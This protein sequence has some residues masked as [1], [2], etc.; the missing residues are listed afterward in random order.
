MHGENSRARPSV[1]LSS[2]TLLVSISASSD[3]SRKLITFL[4]LIGVFFQAGGWTSVYADTE[5]SFVTPHTTQ[6]RTA[7]VVGNESASFFNWSRGIYF[8]PDVDYEDINTFSFMVTYISGATDGVILRIYETTDGTSRG[9]L[10]EESNE[11]PFT[12]FLEDT[13]NN[14]RADCPGLAQ[15][16]TFDLEESCFKANFITDD[17]TFE[18]GQK[19]LILVESIENET[20]PSPYRLSGRSTAAGAE[21]TGQNLT[22]GCKVANSCSV[23]TNSSVWTMWT[24]EGGVVD[25]TTRFDTFVPELGV[26]TPNATSTTF[27]LEVIGY[28]NEADYTTDETNIYMR[29][30]QATGM[31]LRGNSNIGSNG[32]FTW[33]PTTFGEFEATTTAEILNTGVYNIYWSIRKP[34]FSVFGFGFFNNTVLDVV[35]TFV[36]GDDVSETEI[37][38]NQLIIETTGGGIVDVTVPTSETATS[39]LESLPFS[40]GQ[41][42]GLREAI[43]SKFPFNWISGYV[44]VLN[45]LAESEATTTIPSV[46]INYGGLSLLQNVATSTAIDTEITFFSGATIDEVA[47]FTGIQSMRTFLGWVLWLGLIGYASR[48][49]KQMFKSTV[50]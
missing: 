13:G 5:Y 41:A 22:V 21:P 36:V 47:E 49:G 6:S 45:G 19:Y 24:G 18:T 32:E 43:L 3:M 38:Q 46:T 23:T 29:Y 50:G 37:L 16:P 14:W 30:R 26:I 40:W 12:D 42:F 27:A 31:G 10:L 4:L 44:T 25:F 48:A 1:A 7:H 20:T 33:F 34:L 39:T 11:I 2:H 17:I 15:V 9:T 35:G 28:I 8:Q